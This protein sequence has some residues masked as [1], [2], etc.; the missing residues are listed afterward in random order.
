[1]KE[2]GVRSR[3]VSGGARG[4]VRAIHYTLS[5]LTQGNIVP[6]EPV[7]VLL[8]DFPGDATVWQKVMPSITSMPVMAIDLLGFGESEHPC[9]AD[10]SVWGHADVINLALRELEL[11]QIVLVGH[12][13]GGG[14]AQV[15]ATRL[16]PELVKGLILIDS[17]AFQ[18]SFNENWPLL[19]MTKRQELEASHHIQ[20]GELEQMLRI[21]IPQAAADPTQ[22]TGTALERY[23]KPWLSNDG[24]ELLFQQIKNLVPYYLN[25]VSTDLSELNYP[26]LI[27]WGEKDQIF[28]P[29]IGAMLKKWLKQ[30]TLVTIPGAG[31]LILDE[32]PEKVGVAMQSFLAA[33]SV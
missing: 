19:E 1:M 6:A 22:L 33:L 24:K 3:L 14:I 30:S 10:T 9:P 4:S 2:I 15:L 23:I 27:I 5:Y 13:L 7:L 18:Y 25:A 31:H 20:V 26:A 28:P 11:Q 29:K 8:H 17:A 12:G 32:A 21:T 16:M